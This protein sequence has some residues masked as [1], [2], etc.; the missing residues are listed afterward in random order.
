MGGGRERIIIRYRCGGS[1][2]IYLHVII[3]LVLELN[4]GKG[5]I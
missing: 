2:H 4:V 1:Y 3:Q 5:G